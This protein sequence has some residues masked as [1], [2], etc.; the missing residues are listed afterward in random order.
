MTARIKG[1]AAG[2]TEAAKDN[3]PN[4]ESKNLREAFLREEANSKSDFSSA[5]RCSVRAVDSVVLS[6]KIP[7]NSI[8]WETP[9]TLSGLTQRPKDFK[10]SAALAIEAAVASLKRPMMRKSSK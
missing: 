8:C 6:S 9:T 2:R 5:M 1:R 7:R 10:T 4:R 3:L